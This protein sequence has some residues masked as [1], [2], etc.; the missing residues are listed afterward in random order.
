[1]LTPLLVVLC[2]FACGGAIVAADDPPAKLELFAKEGWYKSQKGAEKDF[3]GVLHK[4]DKKKGVVGIGRF[5]PYY[6]VMEADGKTAT[7]E[8]YVG[9]KPDILTPYVGKK[10]KLTGKAVELEVVG[11]VHHEIWPARLEVLVDK[12][13][14]EASRRRDLQVETTIVSGKAELAQDKNE[15]ELKMV[16]R[17]IWRYASAS[18]KGP[19]EGHKLVLRSAAELVAATPFKNL[20]APQQVVEKQA[21]AELAKAL[22][23]DAI[24]WKTHMLVVVTAGVKPTGGYSVD[25]QSIKV[26]DKT[27][28]VAWKLNTPKGAVTQAFT[29][30]GQVALVERFGGEVKFT[31]TA[32]PKNRQPEAKDAPVAQQDKESTETLLKAANQALKDGDKAKAL[33]LAAKAITADEK[34]VLPYYYRGTLYEALE[35]YAKSIADFTKA[36]ALDPKADEGYRLRGLVQFKAGKIKESIADFDKYIELR[37]EAKVSHWQRGISYYY[38]GR[39]DDGAKQFEGYQE[40]DSNDVENAVWRYLCMA[41]KDGVAKARA[42]MLKIGD[43]KRVPMRQIYD[44]YAGKLKPADVLAAAEEGNPD[45]VQLNR[46]LFYAHLYLGLYYETEGD[47]KRALEHITKAANDHR[48]GHYMWDVARVHRDLLAKRKK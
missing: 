35:E 21:T 14:A 6:L 37:P 20:D 29:H 40:F 39:F 31:G 4:M 18:P 10:I 26:A 16:A 38:A 1:M 41:R 11:K 8:V 45:K 22:K 44:L 13:K 34:T 36:I 42:A 2:G 28:T 17:A 30:P 24:D 25:I 46:R 48:I 12:K 19:K 27:A 33:E 7:R 32:A 5:N 43:D 3:V 15:K 47:A 9:G 23:V